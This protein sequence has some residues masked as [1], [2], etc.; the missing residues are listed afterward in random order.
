M[1]ESSADGDGTLNLLL[2]GDGRCTQRIKLNCCG[3]EIAF[4][5]LV[6]WHP[7]PLSLSLAL[8]KFP[9]CLL[10]VTLSSLLKSMSDIS[11]EGFDG[12]AIRVISNSCEDWSPMWSETLTFP[13]K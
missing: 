2:E 12:V 6:F 7:L 4:A 9:Y 11:E 3:Q 8:V 5:L 1:R 10:E 13:R